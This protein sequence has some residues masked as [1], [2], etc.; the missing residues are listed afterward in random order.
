MTKHKPQIDNLLAALL[1]AR[2]A[3]DDTDR[4]LAVAVYRRLALGQPVAETDLAADTNQTAERVHELLSSWPGVFRD[5]QQQVVGFWGLTITD[6]PPHRYRVRD[7]Q[8]STWC[9]W[10]TLFITRILGAPAHVESA[11]AETGA[12]MTLTVTPAGVADAP[13][14]QLALSFLD[15]TGR[16]DA[17]IIQNF[18][19][20]V[21]FFA[22]ASNGERWCAKN[23]GTYL[24]ALDD[25]VA[26]AHGYADAL[27][28]S[29][30]GSSL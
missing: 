25:A 8:L 4:E 9:A 15:P 1:A 30:C 18:C 26:V 22:S 23:P 24:L 17:D 20:Y 27:L 11:D 12:P 21:H 7:V 3:M 13:H 29:S 19:H 2:P 6:M 28:A 10:D 5:D 16:F 14:P